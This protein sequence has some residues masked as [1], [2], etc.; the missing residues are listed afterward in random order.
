MYESSNDNIENPKPTKQIKNHL[1]N[2]DKTSQKKKMRKDSWPRARA[3][4]RIHC[5]DVKSKKMW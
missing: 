3:Y 2:N 1:E 4:K 5:D